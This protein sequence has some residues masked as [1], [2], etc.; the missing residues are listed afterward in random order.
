MPVRRQ[1]HSSRLDSRSLATTLR[2]PNRAD[3]GGA[4]YRFAKFA[5]VLLAVVFCEAV[6]AQSPRRIPLGPGP[7]I[8]QP[9]SIVS[10]D[11]IQIPIPG[12][13]AWRV[14]YRSGGINSEQ[15]EVSGV[16]IAPTGEPPPGGWPVVAWA[17]GTT[18]IVSK[19]APSLNGNFA[20][21]VPGLAEFIARGYVV[22]A[23]DYQG[24]G[25]R[26]PHPY[27]IGPSEAHSVLD[28]VRAARLVTGAGPRFV[29][30]GH[31]QGGHAALWTG[32]LAESYAPDLTLLGVAAAAPASELAKL[33]EADLS[34]PAG[35]AFTGLALLSWSKVYGLSLKT[36]MNPQAIP[37]MQLIGGSCMNSPLGL[38]GD[39]IGV[40][41]L[42]S[43]VLL[44][45]PTRTPPWS[46]IVAANTPSF[47]AGGAP[48]MIAQGISDPVVVPSITRDFAR[49]LCSAGTAVRLLEV[50]GDHMGVLKSGTAG[51]VE[52]IIQRF[53]GTPPPNDCATM[54][55]RRPR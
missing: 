6:Q 41:M 49:R 48:V 44:S 29:V 32:Q 55:W 17:H 13:R 2:K 3:T 25:T 40:K 45:D 23:T 21:S 52:W 16:I 53:A 7:I 22:A 39:V 46:G 14:V 35:K 12:A 42:P 30:W 8:N 10:A 43:Q 26:G 24:L 51:V 27:L 15:I 50:S 19:C 1:R 11:P 33:L 4:V 5:L 20:S 37:P 18:G 38:L 34:T 9:G 47:V 36:I 28:S 31:S 54:E